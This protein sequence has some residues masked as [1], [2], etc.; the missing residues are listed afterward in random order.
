MHTWNLLAATNRANT[1]FQQSQYLMQQHAGYPPE[2]M[3]QFM[4]PQA[5][6]AHVAWPEDTPNPYGGGGF[7]AKNENMAEDNAGEEDMEQADP[8]HVH[9]AT[10][11]RGNDDDGSD[12]MRG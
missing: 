12:D 6:Q 4:T 2:V 3:E 8:T 9:S 11:T 1:Y 7:F 10:S 5:F